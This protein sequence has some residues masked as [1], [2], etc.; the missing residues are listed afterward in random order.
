MIQAGGLLFAISPGKSLA[1]ES[2]DHQPTCKGTTRQG[3]LESL[4]PSQTLEC[5][6]LDLV[7]FITVI[8]I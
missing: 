2:K 1:S 5:V 6:V 8:L 7:L 3:C 4:I